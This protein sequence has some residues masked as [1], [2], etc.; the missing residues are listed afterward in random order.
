MGTKERE[1][2]LNS[3]DMSNKDAMELLEKTSEQYRIYSELHDIA[4]LAQP[5]VFLDTVTPS[6]DRLLSTTLTPKN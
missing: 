3:G 1:L 4:R 6:A 5:P 2:P